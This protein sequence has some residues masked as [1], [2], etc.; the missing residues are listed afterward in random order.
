MAEPESRRRRS[1]FRERPDEWVHVVT[2]LIFFILINVATDIVSLNGI[3]FT[4]FV[5][6]L[7]GGEIEQNFQDRRGYAKQALDLMA[8]EDV[9]ET[10]LTSKESV[11]ERGFP[12]QWH[13]CT[14]PSLFRS[15][16]EQR[17]DHS[18]LKVVFVG[19]SCTTTSAASCGHREADNTQD[20]RFTDILASSLEGDSFLFVSDNKEA[21]MDFQ[22]VNLGQAGSG[23]VLNALTLDTVIDPKTTDVL[24]YEFFVDDVWTMDHASVL[25]LELW[26]VRVKSLFERVG[27]P[28]PPIMLLFL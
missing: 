12:F 22:I 15:K 18:A 8:V 25:N 7:A 16:D 10:F 19:G 2:I 23:S 27:R 1:S 21:K 4:D 13:P 14:I 24:V 6:Y 17:K 20:A 5:N 28:I 3:V 26:L 11:M 9:F